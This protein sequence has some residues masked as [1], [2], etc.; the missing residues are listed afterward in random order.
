MIPPGKITKTSTLSAIPKFLPPEVQAYVQEFQ[1][2]APQANYETRYHLAVKF[3]NRWKDFASTLAAGA[4]LT[5]FPHVICGYY[6]PSLTSHDYNYLLTIGNC[7]S[8]RGRLKGERDISVVW[9]ALDEKILPTKSAHGLS[10]ACAILEHAKRFHTLSGMSWDSSLQYVLE[11]TLDRHQKGHGTGGWS[12]EF[13]LELENA[14]IGMKSQAANPEKPEPREVGVRSATRGPEPQ[15]AHTTRKRAPKTSPVPGED[16]V[17]AE[18]RLNFFK[19]MD[20]E[21]QGVSEIDAITLR[22]DYQQQ[23]KN[24]VATFRRAVQ[25]YQIG[26]SVVERREVSAAFRALDLITPKSDE[27]I[28]LPLVKARW[29]RLAAMHHPDRGG[30]SE[31]YIAVSDA[32]VLIKALHERHG[33][34]LP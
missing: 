31:K 6:D 29:K 2:R 30:D 13:K 5:K 20:A 12:D 28:D 4:S 19:W 10:T 25:R 33:G 1:E 24:L 18:I 7:G 21:I 22:Q 34:T 17:L 26:I 16:A 14:A 9:Q 27:I 11:R 15:A 8:G 3:L 23:F 32:F